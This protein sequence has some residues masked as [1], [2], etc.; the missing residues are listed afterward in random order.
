MRSY[1]CCRM[2]GATSQ[3]TWPDLSV[4]ASASAI[5]VC[6]DAGIDGF[7]FAAPTHNSVEPLCSN[8]LGA[9]CVISAPDTKDRTTLVGKRCSRYDSMPRLWV[10]LT[11]MQV[12]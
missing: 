10:V 4:M 11:R 7:L 1:C 9:S 8:S 2:F 3:S 12:C 5:S 6:I